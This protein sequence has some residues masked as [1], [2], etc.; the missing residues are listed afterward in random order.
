[1]KNGDKKM[2]GGVVGVYSTKKCGHLLLT[3][4]SSIQNRGEGFC[5]GVT[6]NSN[7][8]NPFTSYRH[9]GLVFDEQKGFS[10]DEIR[11]LCGN[12]GIGSVSPV[13][14]QPISFE[15]SYGKLSLAYSG[16]I[17]N[18][19]A[20][21]NYLKKEGHSLSLKHTDAEILGKLM[22]M[23][24]IDNLVDGVKNMVS[25]VKGAYSLGVLTEKGL[26]AFRSPVGVEPLIVGGNDNFTGFA[27]ESCALKESGLRKNEYRDVRPGELVKIGKGIESIIQLPGKKGICL[28][29]PGYW[30]RI[31]SFFDGIST[32]L[33]RERI[34]IS[35]AKQ[36]IAE[37]FDADVVIP[38]RE[39]GAGFATGYSHGSGIPYDDGFLRNVYVT[40]TFLQRTKKARIKGTNRKQAVIEDA[41]E[42]KRVVVVDD[43]IREGPTMRD[44]LVP[45]LRWAG[46][47]EVHVRIGS[48]E[49]KYPCRYSVFKKSRGK[50]FSVGKTL[51][52][53][54]KELQA[55]SLRFMSLED[56]VE[57]SGVPKEDV[58]LGCWNNEFPI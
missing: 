41:V 5:G 12:Y 50:L 21:T 44:K 15:A 31:D 14:K 30:G 46:A 27:S 13:T 1:L 58:C 24:D 4:L 36:D 56:Y 43:S 53:Q 11:S 35:L 23:K 42:G 38:V 9:E 3:I 20:L 47:K 32:K 51:E 29:E 16:K 45:A 57:A 52:E 18:K 6:K 39:S 55:D 25:K 2:M 33:M 48:P 22:T 26:Y 10:D 28:F 17:L 34:G 37:G 54:R 19:R 49:N 40:R 8:S 7:K